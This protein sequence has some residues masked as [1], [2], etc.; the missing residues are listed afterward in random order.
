M[1]S[2]KIYALFFCLYLETAQC[3]TVLD[4][5][6]ILDSSASVKYYFQ[7]EKNFIK[8][9]ARTFQI[10]EEGTRIGVQCK[11][12]IMLDQYH[13]QTAFETAVDRIPWVN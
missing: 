1:K 12:S 7:N 4:I 3:K 6:F 5:G 13:D 10:G 9:L 8:S 2:Y 11:V